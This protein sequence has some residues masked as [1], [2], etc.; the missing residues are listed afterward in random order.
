MFIG[1][2]APAFAA[3]AISP[4]SPRLG[5]LFVAAQLVDWA[6]FLFVLVG[7]EEMRIVPG[8]TA[9]NPLDLHYMPYTHSLAGTAV[10]ALVFGVIVWRMSRNAVAGVWAG[11]VTLSH[12]LTDLLVHRPDLTL[13]GGPDRFGLGLW[14][15]PLIAIPLELAMTLLAFVWYIRAT[16]GPVGPPLVLIGAM[17]L[18]QTIS[19]FAPEPTVMSVWLPITALVAFAILTML[20]TW[21]GRTRWHKRQTGLAVASARG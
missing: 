15:R 9:M 3:G 17:L 7:I 19:W 8:I 5:T 4:E 21:V 20:A 11:L 16:K 18:L 13:A 14:D 1:H 12:W 10:F 6:F 2:F